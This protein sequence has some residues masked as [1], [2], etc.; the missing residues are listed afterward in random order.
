MKLRIH[1]VVLLFMAVLLSS[2][3]S[4]LFAKEYKV[5]VADYSLWRQ[6]SGWEGNQVPPDNL[7]AGSSIVVPS[8][9]TLVLEQGS[10]TINGA[11]IDVKSGG[12]LSIEGGHLILKDG[13]IQVEGML[14]TSFRGILEIL[15]GT[16]IC[17]TNKFWEYRT[18]SVKVKAGFWKDPVAETQS[19]NTPNLIGTI[20]QFRYYPSSAADFASYITI[21]AYVYATKNQAL[22]AK[23]GLSDYNDFRVVAGLHGGKSVSFE[24]VKYPGYFLTHENFQVKLQPKAS[25]NSSFS[26]EASFSVVP[27]RKSQSVSFRPIDL[28][29]HFLVIHNMKF[30]IKKKPLGAQNFIY[31][32]ERKAQPASPPSSTTSANSSNSSNNS[33]STSSSLVGKLVQFDFAFYPSGYAGYY[34]YANKNQ[35]QSLQKGKGGNNDF[36]VVAGLDGGSTVS[37]ESVQYPGYYLRHEGF[38]M[39]LHPKSGGNATFSKDASFQLV[40]GLAD[41]QKTSS[42]QAVNFPGHYI[43][44]KNFKFILSQVPGIAD[45][46]SA[47]FTMTP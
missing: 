12:T 42:F 37:F 45:K 18:N 8:G 35:Q 22:D 13:M 9:A 32:Y 21:G 10:R 6:A 26:R 46:Q 19:S 5:K 23:L 41:A 24:S 11:N 27:A 39:K 47:S 20:F 25:G 15:G 28:P 33:G 38:Q 31:E 30:E 3:F 7:P 34:L 40:P 2:L 36:R 1:P 4:S 44:H 14:K 16:L 43:M 29:E 17:P